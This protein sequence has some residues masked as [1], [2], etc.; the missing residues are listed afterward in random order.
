MKATTIAAVLAPAAVAN[1]QWWGDAPEC[2]QECFSS[3]WESRTAWPAPTD[4]CTA[5]QGPP[6]ATC[7]SS[8]CSATPTAITS[9]SSLSSSLCANWAS[10]SSAGS[11]GVITVSLPA[12][13]GSWGPGGKFGGGGGPGFGGPGGPGGPGRGPWGGDLG[14]T[15]TWTGGVYTVTGCEWNGS[16]W[17]GGPGG[18]TGGLNGNPWGNWGKGWKW[19]TITQTVTQVVTV[20]ADGTPS[21]STSIGLATV[22]QAVNGDV[23]QTS[24]IAGGAAAP[25]GNAAPKDSAANVKVMGALLGGVV[26]VAGML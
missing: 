11:T 18:W 1:A 17:A 6:V 19:S 21:L 14:A 2:A 7:I 12:F 20:T 15:K 24:I 13:T 4:Y 22:A 8:A 16:P 23:T 5:T 26:A 9:Y 25:T 10:C 3:H